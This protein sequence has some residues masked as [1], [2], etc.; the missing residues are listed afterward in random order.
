MN[1]YRYDLNH[2]SHMVGKTGRLMCHGL[3]PVVGGDSIKIRWD[4]A[5]RLSPLARYMTTDAKCDLFAFYTPFRHIYGDDWIEFI[6]EGTQEA[7]AFPSSVPVGSGCAYLGTPLLTQPFPRW[8]NASYN[9]IW[10]RY[11]RIPTDDASIMSDALVLSTNEDRI[12]GKL[13]AR[14]PAIWTTGV[15]QEYQTSDRQVTVTGGAFDIIDLAQVRRLWKTEVDRQ[16]FGQ[17]YNDVMEQVFGTQVNTD[18]DERPTLL[19]R[20]TGFLSGYDVDGTGDAN[21]GTF[22]GKSIT[23]MMLDV[24]RKFCPEHG[25]ISLMSLVRFPVI[26]QDEYHYLITKPN[27]TYVEISGDPDLWQAQP[28][29]NF[30]TEDFFTQGGPTSLGLIPYGQWYRQQ[31]SVVHSSFTQNQNFAFFNGVPNTIDVARYCQAFE[32]DNVFQ[33][34][35]YGHWQH[36]SAINVE[37]S[38]KVPGPKSSMYAGVN[39]V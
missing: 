38:T 19:A 14:L 7:V 15:D 9:R 31:P 22:S 26:A 34:N 32:Y 37:K 16:W 18:A 39:D 8:V 24:P 28:P 6:K 5:I 25:V 35:A 17:Y 13:C 29:E 4:G 2:Q 12:Y 3:I 21:L 36:H 1:R 10:N 30:L 11:F 27:P 20:E 23:R 33:T